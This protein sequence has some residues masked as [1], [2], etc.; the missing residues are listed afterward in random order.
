[1]QLPR[2]FLF[3]FLTFSL[4]HSIWAAAQVI[5]APT[6]ERDFLMDGDSEDPARDGV[7][8][9]M[10]AIIYTTIDDDVELAAYQV[11]WTLQAYESG[12][13]SA[14]TLGDGTTTQLSDTTAVALTYD[15]DDATPS[16]ETIE[17]SQ[18]TSWIEPNPLKSITL[19]LMLVIYQNSFMLCSD[20]KS[21]MAQDTP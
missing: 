12:S 15:P 4:S 10:S 14:V 6:I 19:N 5:Y 17:I 20:E 8:V 18:G 3:L 21:S 2:I 1:M 13:W 9:S 11:E 16:F 7:A